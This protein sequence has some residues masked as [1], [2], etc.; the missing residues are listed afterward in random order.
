MM[1]HFK[2]NHAEGSILC[3]ECQRPIRVRNFEN[4]V[5]HYQRLHPFKKV[6]FAGGNEDGPS[7]LDA[8]VNSFRKY[9]AIGIYQRS[10]PEF[11]LLFPTGCIARG[12]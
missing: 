8:M 12:G 10:K 2:N 3:Y 9:M 6:P 11:F 5:Q 1:Q 7:N 4:Y